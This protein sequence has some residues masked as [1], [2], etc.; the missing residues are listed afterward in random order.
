MQFVQALPPLKGPFGGTVVQVGS[1]QFDD[2]QMPA[3][4]DIDDRCRKVDRIHPLVGQGA[5]LPGRHLDDH[6]ESLL[7]GGHRLELRDHGWRSAGPV[8]AARTMQ[9]EQRRTA[10]QQ[11]GKGCNQ[12][13]RLGGEG[14]VQRPPLGDD[15][16]GGDRV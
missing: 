15:L 7:T 1:W 14:P 9:V 11:G 5:H 2:R 16:I 8:G 12:R 4:G 10:D 6:P 13:Q 3:L